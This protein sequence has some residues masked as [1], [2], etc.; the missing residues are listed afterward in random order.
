MYIAVAGKDRGDLH[1]QPSI[2]LTFLTKMVIFGY[3][4]VFKSPFLSGKE[5]LV[6]YKWFKRKTSTEFL[7]ENQQKGGGGIK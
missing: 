4:W 7:E 2:S 3:L 6:E 5:K 1:V